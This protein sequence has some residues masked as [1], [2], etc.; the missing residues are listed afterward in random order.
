MYWDTVTINVDVDEIIGKIPSDKLEKELEERNDLM[1]RDP[2]KA[3]KEERWRYD[4]V[5]YELDPDDYD[6]VDKENIDLTEID[7]D[8]LVSTVEG[9]GYTVIDEDEYTP[10]SRPK[11]EYV[12]S[13]RVRNLRKYQFR[14]FLCDVVG[15]Q[16]TA[17]TET[18]LNGVKEML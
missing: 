12:L 2:E 16:H 8:K 4:T 1:D 3:A 7:I 10:K 11:V 18:I 5:E 13:D 15:V 9:Y 6:L 17:S 14:D